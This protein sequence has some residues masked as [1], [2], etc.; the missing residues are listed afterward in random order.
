MTRQTGLI[1]D[2]QGHLHIRHDLVRPKP[3]PKQV[4]VK[5]LYIGISQL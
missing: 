4:L 3:A 1:A 2:E 5:S